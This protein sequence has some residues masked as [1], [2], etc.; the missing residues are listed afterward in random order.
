MTSAGTP[1]QLRSAPALTAA[2][3]DALDNRFSDAHPTDILRWA[4]ATF[5]SDLCLTTSFQDTLLI[6]LAIAVDPDLEVVFLDTGFHFA[7]TLDVLRRAMIRYELHLRVE[8]PDEDAPDLWAAGSDACCVARKVAPLDRAL[9]GKRAWLSGLRRD[10]S[11]TRADTRIVDVDR[12]GLVKINPLAAWSA[13]AAAAWIADHDVI[14]NPLFADGFGSVGCW[15]CTERPES[16]AGARS[17][18][19]NGTTKTECGIHQ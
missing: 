5:G 6:D 17:G 11:A 8:R 2:Q 9:A 18:R 16:G 10:D 19:W 1:V 15:P 7:E 12:R 4:T 14:V 3:A 13:D